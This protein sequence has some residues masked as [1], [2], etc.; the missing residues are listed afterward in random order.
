MT[1]QQETNHPV[2]NL[3]LGALPADEYHRLTR[4]LESVSLTQGQVIYDSGNPIN[5]VY[6]PNNGMVSLLSMTAEGEIVEVAMVGNEGMLGMP[7]V[8][9]TNAAPYQVMVQ[10]AGSGLALRAAVLK[11]ELRRHG[12]LHDLL[13]RYTHA[14]VSQISQSAICNR[15]HSISQRLC[16]CLLIA[17]DRMGSDDFLLTQEF[18]AHMLGSRRERI[19]QAANA[20]QMRDLIRYKRGRITILNPRGLES[21]SCECYQIIKE[22]YREVLGI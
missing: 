21:V 2:R 13:L 4:D 6:F 5:Q 15:F 22:T 8:W 16:R 7:I 14:L 3:I 20:L 10:I 9:G 12:V 1:H 17:H 11:D 18:I 19:T